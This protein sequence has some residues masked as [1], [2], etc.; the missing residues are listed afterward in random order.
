V[1]QDRAETLVNDTIGDRRSHH[2][3]RKH[4]ERRRARRDSGHGDISQ[5]LSSGT[6]LSQIRHD[7]L[8][9]TAHCIWQAAR[10]A[11]GSD[12]QPPRLPPLR[13]PLQEKKK[14][15]AEA[16]TGR[17][18]GVMINRFDR[19]IMV[20]FSRIVAVAATRAAKQYLGRPIDDQLI[21]S[22]AESKTLSRPNSCHPRS[23]CRMNTTLRWRMIVESH[24]EIL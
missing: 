9:T 1:W 17:V 13:K 12:R 5:R 8:R 14:H 3:R 4:G 16:A 7:R 18:R 21:G 15:E 20:A 22:A 11:G 23:A 2:Y 6:A 19:T 24:R 10:A